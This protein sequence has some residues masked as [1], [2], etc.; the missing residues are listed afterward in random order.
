MIGGS[1][2]FSFEIL[3]T[4]TFVKRH[5]ILAFW[6]RSALKIIRDSLRCLISLLFQKVND[7]VF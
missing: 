5:G 7:K 2:I 1:S 6:P 4:F 3:V